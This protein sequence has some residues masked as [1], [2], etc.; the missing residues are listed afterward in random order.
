MGEAFH[1]YTVI[2]VIKVESE[3]K[4]A[5]EEGEEEEEEEEITIIEDGVK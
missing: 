3:T 4:A 1:P 2:P 5:A